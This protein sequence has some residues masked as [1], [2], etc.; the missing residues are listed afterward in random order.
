MNG[1]HIVFIKADLTAEGEPLTVLPCENHRRA[2]CQ[3]FTALQRPDRVRTWNKIGR[4]AATGCPTVE[5]I[6][7]I[8]CASRLEQGNNIAVSVKCLTVLLQLKLVKAPAQKRNCAFNMAAFDFDTRCI[9]S[10]LDLGGDDWF[11]A[12][13]CQRHAGC[14]ARYGL[15]GWRRCCK[16]L[17]AWFGRRKENA[18]SQNDKHAKRNSENEILVLIVHEDPSPLPLRVWQVQQSDGPKVK[19]LLVLWGK[20]KRES[21]LKCCR[22]LPEAITGNGALMPLGCIIPVVKWPFR[23]ESVEEYLVWCCVE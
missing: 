13:R 18:P 6:V 17:R 16:V 2:W 15:T 23:L 9:C 22:I 7:G 3:N 8:L 4:E 19:R 12:G 1:K 10:S 11:C 5:R 20:R 14:V 21:C